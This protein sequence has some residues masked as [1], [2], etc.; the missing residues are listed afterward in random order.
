[1]S[2]LRSMQDSK[3]YDMMDAKIVE[4]HT[5]ESPQFRFHQ[6]RLCLQRR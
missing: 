4:E 6:Y 3:S 2:D 1:M 5:D